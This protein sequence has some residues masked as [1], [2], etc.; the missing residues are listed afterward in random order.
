MMKLERDH[1]A[2]PLPPPR[3]ASILHPPTL[4]PPRPQVDQERAAKATLK[5]NAIEGPAEVK[6]PQLVKLVDPES[7]VGS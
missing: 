6:L 3:P 7:S 4:P 5:W 1:A 2:F